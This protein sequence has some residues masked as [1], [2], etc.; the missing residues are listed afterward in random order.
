[1][2]RVNSKN[3]VGLEKGNYVSFEEIGHSSDFYKEGAKLYVCE[4]NAKEQWFAITGTESPDMS[5]K[6][7]W[8]L[9]K[10]VSPQDIFRLTNGSSADRSIIANIAFRIATW[11]TIF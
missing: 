7:K 8:G 3:L 11:C 4:V 2:T 5:K 6:V 1:M 9:A 10:D